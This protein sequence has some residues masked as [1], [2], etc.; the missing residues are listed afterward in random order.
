ME[1]KI[2]LPRST[3]EAQGVSSA[4]ITDFLEAVQNKQLEL[5]SLM[6]LRHGHVVA[7][8]WW[9]PYAA[10]LPHMMF[11]LSKSFTSTAIG[12]A[13]A[14]G[15][16][17]LDD[18]VVSFFPEEA[19]DDVSPN[20]ASMHIRHLLMMGTGHAQDTTPSLRREEG[21]SWVKTFLHAPVEHAPGTYFVYNSGA[22]YML[23]AILQKVTGD[24]LLDYLQPRLMEPLGIYGA[25]WET[26]PR[27][28]HVGGWGLNIKT[29]DI[30]K[31]GQ[32]YLQEGIWNGQRIISE[33]WVREATSKHI[34]NGNGGESD[35]AQGYGYQF[36]RC[37]HNI[38]RGDGKYGQ[39]CV[40]MPEQDAVVA[41][42]SGTNDLQGVL[43]LVWKH[44]LPAM[45][46]QPDAPNEKEAS[47]LTARLSKLSLHPPRPISESAMEE[48]VSGMVFLLDDN[49]EQWST[50]SI[51]FEPNAAIASIRS[52][53][54]EHM[55]RFGR[56]A[57]VE[58]MSSIRQG[59]AR[60]IASSFS[61]QNPDTLALSACLVETPFHYTMICQWEQD[62]L[63]LELLP[64]V[65]DTNAPIQIRGRL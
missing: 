50:F 61:W 35:W 4:A 17:S 25:T 20:L 55:I 53:T 28:I 48:K 40:V 31:F 59:A 9:A 64:N 12:L 46:P 37:R 58:G 44:L 24:K 21:A 29:E 19:P 2:L 15:I 8:G 36:W 10:D 23:S 47:A 39:F 7:E 18:A 65:S 34:S 63:K 22:T 52:H 16:V 1:T 54:G 49:E 60:R 42:T 14:E 51:R 33:A 5:H 30:A 38:Y 27:G 3:P 6:V 26:C 56:G 57:W 13:V 11:S 43:N 62:E 32:L 41:M 45:K